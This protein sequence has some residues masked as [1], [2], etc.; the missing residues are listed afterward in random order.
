M[1]LG[2]QTELDRLQQILDGLDPAGPP[3]IAP[4]LRAPEGIHRPGQ[5][6]GVFSGSF[7]PL[8]RPHVRI[9][10]LAQQRHALD[11]VLLLIARVNVDK[12]D[13][14]ASLT[15]RLWMLEQLARSRRDLSVAASSHGRFIEKV[16]AVREVYPD[17][18][19]IY[20]VVGFDTLVRI[21]DP[22]YYTDPQQALADLFRQSEMIVANRG[23]ADLPAVRRW[24]DDPQRRPFSRRIHLIELDEFHAGI[25][26][27]LV[28]QRVREGKPIDDLVPP[29][30]AA[31]IEQKGL[32]R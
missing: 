18:T 24:L 10:E 11:E 26:A 13:F 25:S 27:T 31:L 1:A 28:R 6:L 20:F 29:E 5:K 17:E 32:Y 22:K 14:G 12:A 7:D 15:E 21:F 23:S 2:D 30:I 19:A 9:M 8:T 16:R 3:R 4:I